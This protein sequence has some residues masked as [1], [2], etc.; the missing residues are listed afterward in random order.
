VLR[1]ARVCD[2]AVK[3]FLARLAHL[4]GDVDGRAQTVQGLR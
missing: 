3:C 4:V 1:V 2:E